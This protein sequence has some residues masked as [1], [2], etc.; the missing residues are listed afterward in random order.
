MFSRA[1]LYKEF[2]PPQI[3]DKD[4]IRAECNGVPYLLDKGLPIGRNKQPYQP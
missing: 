1:V 3:D 2:Q 4:F